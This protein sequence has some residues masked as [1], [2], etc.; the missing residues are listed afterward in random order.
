MG[1]PELR[2]CICLPRWGRV[3]SGWS[4]KTL[5]GVRH[6]SRLQSVS[7]VPRYHPGSASWPLSSSSG[8]FRSHDQVFVKK[9]NFGR[10]GHFDQFPTSDLLPHKCIPSLDGSTASSTQV[11]SNPS[12]FE[13]A[14]FC[15][16]VDPATVSAEKCSSS[17]SSHLAVAPANFSLV[18]CTPQ[19]R[20]GRD[21]RMS[22]TS[23]P[24]KP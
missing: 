13:L 18:S 1:D 20:L 2:E 10:V 7:R 15:K 8:S 3:K 4:W 11:D 19:G 17:R 22:P 5:S 14:S 23:L 9:K 21:N 16:E 24:H 12:P 6:Q